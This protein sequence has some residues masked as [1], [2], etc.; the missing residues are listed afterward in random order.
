MKFKMYSNTVYA[1]DIKNKIHF[2]KQN[3]FIFKSIVNNC[4]WLG[5]TDT[6]FSC[7]FCCFKCFLIGSHDMLSFSLVIQLYPYFHRLITHSLLDCAYFTL[8]NIRWFYSS[9]EILKEGTGFTGS[10]CPYIYLSSLILSLLHLPKPPPCYFTLSDTR[11]FYSSRE[12]L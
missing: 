12:S 5:T 1:I 8:S 9:M 3:R 2:Q 4:P 11:Q 10:I 7:A 6:F